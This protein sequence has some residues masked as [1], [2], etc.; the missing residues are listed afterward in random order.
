MNLRVLTQKYMGWCPG[1]KAAARFM[2]DKDIPEI[3]VIGSTFAVILVGVYYS[4]LT[5]PPV[6]EARQAMK[7]G[8]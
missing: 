8:W 1:V 7:F 5:P 4:N 2:P 6:W 3:Y